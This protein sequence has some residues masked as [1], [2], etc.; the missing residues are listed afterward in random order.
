MVYSEH[1]LQSTNIDDLDVEIR[2]AV[3]SAKADD[4]RL[5]KLY[6]EKR[7]LDKDNKK[8]SASIKKVLRVMIYGSLIHFYLNKKGSETNTTEYQFLMN[9]YPEYVSFDNENEV[10]FYIS[11]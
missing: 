1:K 2:F 4:G 7:E 8:L 10:V 5:I 9:K 6:F 11:I 3:A